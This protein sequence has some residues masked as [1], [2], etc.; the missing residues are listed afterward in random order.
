MTTR[1]PILVVLATLA[2][3]CG[4]K[5]GDA[6]PAAS[7][8]TKAA[9][10]DPTIDAM[11]RSASTC[12][13]Y[14]YG[15][16]DSSCPAYKT[17]TE[18]K[19]AFNEGK[20]DAS[21]VALL[22]DGDEKIRYLAAAKLN[23][24][25]KAFHTDKTLAQSVVTAAEKEQRKFAQ[26]EIAAAAGQIQ[27]RAT[28][29]FDRVKALVAKRD[30]PDVRRGILSNLLYNNQD[31]DAVYDL[32]RET[33]KDADGT[34]AQAA[35]GSFWAG[36]GHKPDKTCQVYAENLGNGNDEVA[37]ASCDYLAW[38]GRCTS[39]YDGLLDALEK[40]VK[41]GPVSFTSHVTAARHLCDDTK[42]SDAQRKRAAAFGRTIAGKKDTKAWIRSSAL[43]AVI[44]CDLGN[45]GRSFVGKFKADP[46]KTVADK[47]KD[48]LAKK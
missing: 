8:S 37:A 17:W 5:G 34:V 48:L 20:A 4:A 46:E 24:Y 42:A 23:Q 13:S 35:L 2:T 44:H 29:T 27:V 41:A 25:G 18:A 11:A 36:G 12:K 15:G 30:M 1:L 3:G 31:D 21:L 33:V 38:S 16:F 14:D 39:R 6:A 9:A 22:S 43:E 40:R 47:A 28:G 7:A 32:V 45:G 26:K 19:D 10:V